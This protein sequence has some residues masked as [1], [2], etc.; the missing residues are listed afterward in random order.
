[1]TEAWFYV[2]EQPGPE[3]RLQ[4]LVRLLERALRS[5]RQL[6]VHSENESTVTGISDHLW[7]GARFL[8]HG[9]AGKHPGQQLI[10]GHGPDP[11]DH[12]DILVNLSPD[13]P[14]HFSRFQRVVELVSGDDQARQ[15]SREKWTFY[16]H[17]GY[18]VARH[19]LG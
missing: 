15:Q 10:L 4:L 11:G 5:P 1:M 16:K 8:P 13:I 12:H 2:T 6:Y 3:A 14:D 19:E 9:M 18:S 17:R 7:Q